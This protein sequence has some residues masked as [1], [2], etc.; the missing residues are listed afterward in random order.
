VS[1]AQAITPE[2]REA[3]REAAKDRLAI[4]KLSW[5][6]KRL[7]H[8]VEPGVKLEWSWHLDA[9]C[10]ALDLQMA[11]DMAY[12]RLA[13]FVP[14]GTMKS[15]LVSV[16]APAKEWLKD[17][18]R[19]KLFLANDDDLV[20][21]DSRRTRLLIQ[22]DGYQRLLARAEQDLGL[23]AW[24][25]AGDQNEKTNFENDYRGFRQCRPIMGKIT[26]KRGDDIVEDD[27]LDA[28][29]VVLGAPDAI[30][31]RVADVNKIRSQVLPTRVNDLRTA[32]RTLIM[33]RLHQDDPG[34]HAVD[35]GWRIICFPMEYD[36][37]HPHVCPEDIRT[38]LGELL[39]PARFSRAVVD[40]L[41]RSLGAQQAAAQL[42]QLPTP[43]E[44]LR[45]KRHLWGRYTGNP[46]DVAANALEV[47]TSTDCAN[48]EKKEAAFSVIHVLGRFK[49]PIGYRIRVLDE[50][51]AQVE[52]DDLEAG[53]L[54]MARRWP[55]TSQHL[56]EYAANGIALYQRMS[57]RYPGC[58]KVKPK[59]DKQFPGG[60]KED[61]AAHTL[62]KL[63][64]GELEL[65]EDKWAPWAQEI[66]E[67]H[68]A[69]PAGTYKDRV[70]TISQACVRWTVH[71]RAG[72]WAA[73]MEQVKDRRAGLPSQSGMG[74]LDSG[75][76]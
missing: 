76:F 51:R 68:A 15:L 56:I 2:L 61:R 8:V 23:P 46:Q 34:Q 24:G 25:F 26:G 54:M 31:R 59:G 63:Q 4:E 9:V 22:S 38:E 19:R 64:A 3:V 49:T 6:V 39:F 12:Q 37:N 40:L 74:W 33:Q 13:F 73:A 44:G 65:P 58:V 50:W 32:R 71:D 70:D 29:Q 55:Q 10:D 36:P 75:N 17:P 42:Q 27:L 30:A 72:T 62:A 28:K 1:T 57:K 69:F 35:E 45:F 5:F 48:E 53:W 41:K 60:S 14:P 16:F 52:I 11:G 20:K 21:R 47:W 67:E 7:W 43:P 66:I 18:T